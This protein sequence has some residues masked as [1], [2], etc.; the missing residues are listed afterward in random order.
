MIPLSPDA[1]RGL[2]TALAGYTGNG[3]VFLGECFFHTVEALVAVEQAEGIDPMALFVL[4]AFEFAVPS[5]VERLDKVLHLGRQVTRQLIGS[6]IANGLLLESSDSFQL[7]DQGHATLQTGRLVRRILLRRLF[8]FLHPSLLYVAV[9]DPKGNLLCDLS[10][11]RAPTPWEFEPTTLHQ[12]IAQ[13]AEWKR[14]H[15]FPQDI[16][17]VITSP[18][19]PDPSENPALK[20]PDTAGPTPAPVSLQHLIVNKAQVITWRWWLTQRTRTRRN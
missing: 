16:V 14:W 9:H 20:V 1:V 13:T 17:E 3:T 19:S 12:V 18:V 2:W 15:R 10:P 7:T 6:L 11:S 4:R 8:H 5:D